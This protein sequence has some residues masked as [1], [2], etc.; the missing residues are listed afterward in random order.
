[1]TRT[2]FIDEFLKIFGWDVANKNAQSQKKADVVQEQSH[3]T[4]EK[5]WGRPDY[6]LRIEGENRLPVEAKKPSVKLADNDR[7]ATQT[8]SYGWTLSVPAAILTNFAEIAIYDTRQQQ[9]A[10]SN[11]DYA[12]IP[13]CRWTS[14]E[15][16]TC[17]DTLWEYLSYESI[18]T[19]KYQQLYG[20]APHYRAIDSFD[21]SFLSVFRKWRISLANDLFKK[22]PGITITQVN[23]QTQQILNAL[24]F[25]RV[26][27]DRNILYYEE[28][29]KSAKLSELEK[30]FRQKDR[31]FNAGIFQA[32]K[33]ISFT[34]A[35]ILQIVT[36]MYWPN[37]QFAYSLI[38]SE[39]LARIY[40]QYLTEQ[41][42]LDSSSELVLVTKPEVIHAGGIAR[43][44]MP[45]VS[46]I[47]SGVIEESTQRVS[48]RPRILDFAVGSGIFLLEALRQF[49]QRELDQGRK[50]SIALRSEIA[51][52]CLFGIDLDGAAIEV[53][54]ISLLLEILGDEEVDSN[55]SHQILP[56]LSHNL[57]IGNTV[58]REDY[59]SIFPFEASDIA[60]RTK[61]LPTDIYH[62][63]ALPPGTKFDAVIGN[64]PYVRI[65]TLND[66][67]PE[68]LA[69]LQHQKSNYV[70]P[71]NGNFDLYMVF[72]ERALE[73]ISNNGVVSTIVPNRF[74]GNISA[75]GLRDKLLPHL[76]S[77]TDFGVDQIFE[78]KTTYVCILTL[79]SAD[80][81]DF[82]VNR[83]NSY[84]AWVNDQNATNSTVCA[85]QDYSGTS[86]TFVDSSDAVTFD[87]MRNSS[88]ITLSQAANIFVGVQ[89][90]LDEVY[91]V[92][93]VREISPTLSQFTTFNGQ[94]W[95]I[96]TSMLRPS[97]K[98][99]TIASYDGQPLPDSAAIFPYEIDKSGKRPKAVPYSLEVMKSKF[100]YALAYFKHFEKRL[101]ARSMKIST[102]DTFWAYARS[103]SLTKL[104]EPKI[105]ARVLATKPSYALDTEGMVIPGGGDGG[106]YY[107]LRAK[108]LTATEDSIFDNDVI[109]AVLCHPV[110]DRFVAENG[111]KYRGAYAV[112]KKAQLAEVPLPPLSK[113]DSTVIR[114]LMVQIRSLTK[115]LTFP[116]DNKTHLALEGRK[117]VLTSKVERI[118]SD[119]YEIDG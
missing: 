33:G 108:N 25:M 105:V 67:R 14:D 32:L 114:S 30:Q 57:I 2:H 9:P 65:Q 97:I 49:I 50:N 40:E 53:T 15:Y 63:F 48:T 3:A 31:I 80:E 29:L 74:F 110:V 39:M 54:R 101:R 55:T 113:E 52:K 81:N 100:P 88:N 94:K 59:D 119:S 79:G 106:P 70:S 47:V 68:E 90:S 43:T 6:I 92:Y 44:P 1:E 51:Q 115:Q 12:L 73:L 85:K 84:H 116:H 4:S 13:G 66:F 62:Q 27:E 103:Q 75:K 16:L 34:S 42:Q 112:H 76:R 82:L 64:P 69:Y 77:V 17:F 86:W 93:N 23:Q 8:R 7:I 26:C 24:L 46:R 107:L 102:P 83:A 56:D 21:T 95:K 41:L 104:D 109:Q 61:V 98:D 5:G 19:S 38:D 78:G 11:A 18:S 36:E 118:I 91:F 58:V 37:T 87:R 22:N 71:K 89:T 117:T 111:K 96:E 45:V 10:D 20:E 28:L 35:T 99:Q 60:V 72:L